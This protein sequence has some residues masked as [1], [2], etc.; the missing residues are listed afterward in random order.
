MKIQIV[1][2]IKFERIVYVIIFREY[3]CLDEYGL[4]FFA[5]SFFNDLSFQ[6]ALDTRLERL[7]NNENE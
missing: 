7:Q 2:G 4:F 1:V 3:I 5:P 6:I